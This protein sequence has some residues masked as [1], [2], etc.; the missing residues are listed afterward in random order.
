MEVD[1]QAPSYHGQTVRGLPISKPF[2]IKT[3]DRSEKVSDTKSEIGIFVILPLQTANTSTHVI[4]FS[5][6]HETRENVTETAKCGAE[7]NVE[8]LT[9]ASENCNY[10]ISNEKEITYSS[11]VRTANSKGGI[12]SIDRSSNS[13]LESS[14]ADKNITSQKSVGVQVNLKDQS[15]SAD[16][17]PEEM[18]SWLNSLHREDRDDFDQFQSEKVTVI[19]TEP[20]A[21]IDDPDGNE[22]TKIPVF[23]LQNALYAISRMDE[24]VLNGLSEVQI[25]Q[26]T[27]L[28]S[29]LSRLEKNCLQNKSAKT[30]RRSKQ[31]KECKQN[32]VETNK[33]S[34]LRRKRKVQKEETSELE[35]LK[36]PKLI[37]LENDPE[38]KTSDTRRSTRLRSVGYR[39]DYQD[40]EDKVDQICGYLDEETCDNNEEDDNDA[41]IK[42][43]L[44]D[45]TDDLDMTEET[46][47]H[48]SSSVLYAD[49]SG[50]PETENEEDTV[51]KKDK[52]NILKNKDKIRHKVKTSKNND[53]DYVPVTNR[54]DNTNT[55]NE[56]RENSGSSESD[57]SSKSSRGS[58]KMKKKMKRTKQPKPKKLKLKILKE[59]PETK[60]K[61]PKAKVKKTRITVKLEDH[62][63]KYKKDIFESIARK[64]RGKSAVDRLTEVFI[65]TI[66]EKFSSETV[67][68]MEKHLEAHLNGDLNCKMCSFTASQIGELVKHKREQHKSQMN[69]YVCPECGEGL[70]RLSSYKDHLGN[71]HN[72]AQWKC[73]FCCPEPT[74]HLNKRALRKHKEESHR[75]TG[76]ICEDCDEFFMEKIALDNHKRKQLCSGKEKSFVCDQCGMQ[77]S[78]KV[79]LR[80]H[81]RRVHLKLRPYQCPDCPFAATN[82]QSW[83]SHKLLHQGIRPFSCD[84]CTFTC[85][86]SYQLKSHMRTHSGEKPYKCTQC[87]Y[88]AAW[89]VQLKEHVKLHCTDSAVMC[90]QCGILFKNDRTLS[91]HVKKEHCM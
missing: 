53:P 74:Y 27:S 61:Q 9:D 42:D 65:C 78:C 86:Q 73:R 46:L 91:M 1:A 17:I 8:H 18:Q 87:N 31:V 30:K 47:T 4:D 54:H 50:I 68:G 20:G 34:K 45:E 49:V 89:N 21:S 19:K 55:E 56:E 81:I 38:E 11:S 62:E 23:D 6:Y 28:V 14:M 35:K 44:S 12:P 84:Q 26:I 88:A 24:S 60:E 5:N 41:S 7:N 82:Y 25:R 57:D 58:K 2:K 85:V 83:S 51:V 80:L 36:E 43:Y 59:T 75:D 71:V 76:F 90:Q 13:I 10:V 69:N 64:D 66:C 70:Y 37:K 29:L 79:S 15:D 22:D 33:Q 48:M 72:K 32:S 67:T 16:D 63:D 3:D 39:P 40:V 77:L 52:K